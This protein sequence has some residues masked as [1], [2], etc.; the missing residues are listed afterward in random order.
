MWERHNELPNQ[1]LGELNVIFS[2]NGEAIPIMG[3]F[4]HGFNNFEDA[5]EHAA[6]VGGQ[7]ALAQLRLDWRNV[8]F[9]DELNR[10]IT[11]TII[12][13]QVNNTAVEFSRLMLSFDGTW[14]FIVGVFIPNP[15]E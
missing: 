14:V 2:R 13:R 9:I 7:V 1:P 3:S 8:C 12:R 4:I 11:N 6:T 10:E 15:N 5:E